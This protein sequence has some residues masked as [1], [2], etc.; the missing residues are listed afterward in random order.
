MTRYKT[1]TE[2]KEKTKTVFKQYLASYGWKDSQREPVEFE[3]V[4]Y[5]GQDSGKELFLARNFGCISIYS[6]I[7]GDEF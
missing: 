6:G 4:I 5:L 3:E 7:K 1:L 2:K